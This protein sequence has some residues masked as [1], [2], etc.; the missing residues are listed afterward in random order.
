MDEKVEEY[1]NKQLSPQK[2]ICLKLRTLIIKRFPNINEKIR[3]GVPNYNDKFYIVGLKDSVNL[4]FSIEGL[5][6]SE[7]SL[8]QGTGKTMRHLK[9][10]KLNDID[11]EK[12]T[13]L[14]ELVWKS[15]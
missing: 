9:F 12:I 1:F 3:W 10:K 13:K 5:K 7:I 15:N 8:F 11:S 6:K 4:G 2:E 14:I